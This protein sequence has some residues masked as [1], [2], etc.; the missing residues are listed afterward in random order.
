[1]KS[2]CFI[3]MLLPLCQMNHE[4][5][6]STNLASRAKCQKT[7]LVLEAKINKLKVYVGR[8]FTVEWCLSIME[9]VVPPGCQAG[10]LVQIVQRLVNFF[11]FFERICP[12][13]TC[14]GLVAWYVCTLYTLPGGLV[15]FGEFAGAKVLFK[16]NCGRFWL[17]LTF[18]FTGWPENLS[19]VPLEP[20]SHQNLKAPPLPWAP[21]VFGNL[22]TDVITSFAN[23]LEY[24]RSELTKHLITIIKMW[25]LCPSAVLY[26]CE[27][28]V[29]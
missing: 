13:V 3:R 7:K 10:V 28:L 9:A 12:A 5:C 26:I 17:I 24:C 11:Y 29:R 4:T 27:G 16:W 21:V 1:M 23:V 18:G 14:A 19:S 25:K 15:A 20:Q 8:V 6:H 22:F 2:S